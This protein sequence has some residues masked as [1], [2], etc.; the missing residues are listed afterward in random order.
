M[1]WV[2]IFIEIFKLLCL[3]LKHLR[4]FSHFHLDFLV[5]TLKCICCI[6]KTYRENLMNTFHENIP[7]VDTIKF[8]I[9]AIF[10]LRILGPSNR[11]VVG[12]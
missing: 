4:K 8:N 12:T 1:L 6:K 5:F 9:K 7:A 11:I 10:F 3:K 2:Q